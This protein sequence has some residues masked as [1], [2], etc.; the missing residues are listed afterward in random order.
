[1]PMERARCAECG[2]GIGGAGHI[3]MEGTVRDER[4]ERG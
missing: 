1:M 3:A 2:E 4:M